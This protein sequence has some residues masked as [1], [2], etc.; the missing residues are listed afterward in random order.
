MK[1]ICLIS[2]FYAGPNLTTALITPNKNFGLAPTRATFSNKYS[3]IVMLGT[4][5]LLFVHTLKPLLEVQVCP[6]YS[7]YHTVY[8]KSK[9]AFC[10][11][12]KK[13]LKKDFFKM[14]FLTRPW[15][16]GE[17]AIILPNIR[18]IVHL[19]FL[20]LALFYLGSKYFTF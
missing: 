7:I 9:R 13:K 16:A 6:F 2:P 5:L 19:C 20:R 10:C 17:D 3:K 18:F 1:K 8:I 11:Q 4:F 14:V 12:Q 15:E